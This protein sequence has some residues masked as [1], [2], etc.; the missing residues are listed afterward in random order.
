M[1]D[2][3]KEVFE[4]FWDD[5]YDE[6]FPT[7]DKVRDSIIWQAAC[8]YMRNKSNPLDPLSLYEKL[9]RQR[10]ENKKLREALEFYANTDNFNIG[11]FS[12]TVYEYRGDGKGSTWI[13]KKA[14]EALKE[15]G[16]K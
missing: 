6:T 13:G 3:D 8:E 16:D 11:E 1:N 9:E 12:R 14:R 10:E 7:P 15:V 5:N 4:N 2:K